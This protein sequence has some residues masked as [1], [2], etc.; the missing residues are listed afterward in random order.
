[1]IRITDPA[2]D[3]RFLMRAL[4]SIDALLACERFADVDADT[5]DAAVEAAA[6]F[7]SGVLAPLNRSGDS[8]GA[9]WADTVVTT[10]KGFK[11]AFQAFAQAGYNGVAAAPEAGGLGLPK[12]VA[13]CV[14]EL[15]SS[16]NL[17]F[18]LCPVLNRGA[19]AALSLFGNAFQKEVI[20][21]RL[22]SGEWTGT[23]NLTEPQAGSDLGAIRTAAV[24][25]GDHYAIRGQKIFITY[26]EHDYTPN[27][28]HLV[29]ARIAD[30]PP[31]PRGISLF[32]VPKFLVGPGGEI[33]ERNG[34]YCLSIE[35]KLGIH[36]SP[37]CVMGFGENSV[38]H[39]WL[40][41]EPNR[42][43]EAMFVMM[44]EARFAV[45]VE[46][47]AQC[48]AALCAAVSYAGQRV[49]GRPAGYRGSAPVSIDAHP[50]V[51]RQLLRIKA[52]AEGGRA[53]AIWIA[54]QLDLADA[55]ADAKVRAAARAVAELTVPIFKAWATERSIDAANIAIQVHGGAGF[56]EET[57]VAQILR[58][59][60]IT[61]IYEGTTAIQANDLWSRKIL[62]DSGA[63]ARAVLAGAAATCAALDSAPAAGLKSLAQPL[64]DAI[65]DVA[66]CTDWVLAT[67]KE[68][69]Q[70]V[71]AGAVPFLELF[72]STLVGYLLCHAALRAATVADAAFA[73][74]KAHIAAFFIRHE[75][76]RARSMR[77]A[78]TAGAED[79]LSVIPAE[80]NPASA[81]Q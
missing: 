61:A 6:R 64:R 10:P 12:M 81:G 3:M 1:M 79:I 32:M 43:L 34:V 44:N 70:A 60:R 80:A 47:V 24:P 39:G 14:E 40:I 42:G 46:G 5:I 66:A 38:A 69:P 52:L 45:G 73:E 65:A 25:H 67:A 21:P 7:C 30:A 53:L 18:S 35:H 22:V 62:R 54:S 8:E 75:L 20:L 50:D 29:L 71:A 33:G 28:V 36:G 15:T 72:G 2:T 58:D 56:I 27:I 13:A 37:T 68:R 23:M 59:S 11:Q 17:A 48:Q 77:A 9:H 26:G 16:A 51:A 19:S 63:G 4:G 57:G 41:G 78:I 55:D 76:P 49:Q 31:G 74:D